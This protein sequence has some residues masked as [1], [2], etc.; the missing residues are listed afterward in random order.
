MNA[1]RDSEQANL[2]GQYLATP[3]L[4]GVAGCAGTADGRGFG[5]I[6]RYEHGVVG[7]HW[8]EE[9]YIRFLEAS[10]GV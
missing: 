4:A 2:A 6:K 7:C 8:T 1:T 10:W 9:I 5:W 3:G